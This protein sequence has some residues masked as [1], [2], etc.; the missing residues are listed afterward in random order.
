MAIFLI[1]KKSQVAGDLTYEL[2]STA[3][4]HSAFRIPPMRAVVWP[5]S[6]LFFSLA[7]S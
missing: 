5:Q 3:V 2:L 1:R 6:A 7:P 4:F